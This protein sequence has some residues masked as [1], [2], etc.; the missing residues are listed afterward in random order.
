M[1]KFLLTIII[2]GLWGCNNSHKLI[3][4]KVIE[5]KVCMWKEVIAFIPKKYISFS[6]SSYTISTIHG[7]YHLDLEADVLMFKIKEGL[8]LVAKNGSHYESI[9]FITQNKCN[10]ES[11]PLIKSVTV[12]DYNT[13][14]QL[15]INLWDH[16][17]RIWIINYFNDEIISYLNI[18]ND[19]FDPCYDCSSTTE[20]K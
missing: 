6:D 15:V 18:K 9:Y 16:G 5:P 14:Y 7:N 3:Q 2:Y 12:A 1:N 17:E 13:Y 10:F 11:Y 20:T 8:I 4:P 19:P